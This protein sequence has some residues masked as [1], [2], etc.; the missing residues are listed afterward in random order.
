MKGIEIV[1]KEAKRRFVGLNTEEVSLVDTP[2]NEVEFLVVKNTEDPSMGAT[3][4]VE[5]EVVPVELD[6]TADD[7]VTKALAHVSGIVD[8]IAGL[9]NTKKE[10][11]APSGEEP[12]NDSTED[13]ADE[14]ETETETETTETGETEAADVS[15][16]GTSMKSVLQACGMDKAMIKTVMAKMKAAG[17]MAGDAPAGKPPQGG[18]QKTSKAAKTGDDAPFTMLDFAAAVQ[19][20]AAFTPARIE[21]LKQVQ[22]TLKL[23]LEAVA[24]GSAPDA[25]VPKVQSHGN[26]SAV[27]TLTTPNTKP[28]VPT[29]K[30]SD[31]LVETLKALGD[32]L[33]TVSTRLEA[34]EK[35]RPASNSADPEG[36]T[37]TGTK[38]N[39]SLWSGVL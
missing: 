10:A 15:K 5:K 39:T 13:A 32:G 7:N 22:E 27:A 20:A 30:S 1:P 25:N 19:K 6:A 12:S 4:K 3:A 26:A 34:I 35:A 24:P 29:M 21:A 11:K 37:D 8:K 18:A 36:A 2:A 23:M 17:F 16:G 33:A 31:E 28:N 9:V 14:G 38:K